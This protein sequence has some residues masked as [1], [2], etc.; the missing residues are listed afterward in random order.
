[1]RDL[2]TIFKKSEK[3]GR[4]VLVAYP[5]PSRHDS[6]LVIDPRKWGDLGQ[7]CPIL[8]E[9]VRDDSSRI[10]PQTLK[11]IQVQGGKIVIIVRNSNRG[12][13]CEI[14]FY[15][16]RAD[17]EAS[18]KPFKVLKVDAGIMG[19]RVSQNQR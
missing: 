6:L 14:S 7:Y 17:E 12:E 4:V 11:Q 8:K 1:M 19:L 5:C 10:Y 13:K 3:K 16:V 2:K 9:V 18:A 15:S